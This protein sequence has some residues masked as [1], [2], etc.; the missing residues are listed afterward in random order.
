M[1]DADDDWLFAGCL[2]DRGRQACDPAVA[3]GLCFKF[4]HDWNCMIDRHRPDIIHFF[5]AETIEIRH[6]SAL[7]PLDAAPQMNITSHHP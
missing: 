2:C 7:P 3:E 4:H 6:M 1:A 5:S